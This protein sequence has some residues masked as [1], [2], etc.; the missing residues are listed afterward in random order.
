MKE[1]DR[2]FAV[3]N[4][5]VRFHYLFRA[6]AFH[7]TIL[8]FDL[9]NLFEFRILWDEPRITWTILREIFVLRRSKAVGSNAFQGDLLSSMED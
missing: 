2:E 8:L 4:S 9:S 6:M 1:Y 7:R 3:G 5:W